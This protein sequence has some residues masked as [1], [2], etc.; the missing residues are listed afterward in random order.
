MNRARVTRMLAAA[1]AAG[2][3]GMQTLR[4]QAADAVSLEQL[5]QKV[6]ILE[7]KLELA[8][9]AAAAKAKEMPVVNAGKEG[10]S[11]SSADNSYQL[12]LRGYVQGDGRFFLDDS[13]KKSID[14]F[15]MRRARLIFEGR[16]GKPFDFRI[17]PDFGNGKAELQDAFVD[18]RSGDLLNLR[19]GRSR[20]PFGLER[21]QS[22]ADTLFAETG[23]ATALTPNFDEGVTLYGSVHTGVVDYAIGVFNGGPD[24]ASVDADA[25]D[26]KDLV[27]RVFLTPFKYS[28]AAALSGLSIG[29]AG[30][31]GEQD[32]TAA[33]PGLPSFRTSGQQTFFSYMSST[34]VAAVAFADGPRTRL[35]PQ[36]YYVVG[37][38]G[39]M[40]EYIISEQDVATA[41]R[42]DTLRNDAWQAAASYVLTGEAPSLRG[43]TPRL[44]FDRSKGQWGAFEVAARIG[45]LNV[46]DDAFSGGFADSRKSAESA[47]SRGVGLNWYLS[48]NMKVMLDYEQTAFDGGA[49]KG[50]RPDEQL[51]LT[52]VQFSF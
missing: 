36:M 48:R 19:L 44:P 9:E 45:E 25:N 8:D 34:N 20:V 3:T 14:T 43:V 21:L 5:D 23:L 11:L 27:A 1:V 35:A 49:A 52:R 17:V 41:G 46:D 16:L 30:T 18:C 33:S 47:Q 38:F 10:F 50:D 42:S 7:R 32:G 40:G 39:L 24:G 37:S 2:M 51:L 26:S 31:F 22:S 15:V 13:E 6:K 29:I 12:K 28:D 4:A